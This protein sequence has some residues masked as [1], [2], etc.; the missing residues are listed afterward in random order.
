[1]LRWRLDCHAEMGETCDAFLA[2]HV[3]ALYMIAFSRR[4]IEHHQH[5]SVCARSPVVLH[6]Y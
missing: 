3:V 4:G 1:M 5:S 2:S 6:I